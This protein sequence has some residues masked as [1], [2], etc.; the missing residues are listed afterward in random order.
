MLKELIVEG[1]MIIRT[2]ITGRRKKEKDR[3]LPLLLLDDENVVLFRRSFCCLMM[4]EG[5]D[6][7]L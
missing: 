4:A 5:M 7:R 3:E 2:E 6:C 1:R